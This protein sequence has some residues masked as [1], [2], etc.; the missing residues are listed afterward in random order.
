[1]KQWVELST[2]LNL[3]RIKIASLVDMA[4]KRLVDSDPYQDS[5]TAAGAMQLSLWGR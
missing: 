5:E 1:M 3:N 4:L 2:R